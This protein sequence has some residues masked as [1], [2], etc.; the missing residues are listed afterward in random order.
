[1]NE[2]PPGIQAKLLVEIVVIHSELLLDLCLHRL[3]VRM[4]PVAS[5]LV[6]RHL[7]KVDCEV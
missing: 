7:D 1:M 3:D 6:G 4:L 2:A 5:L